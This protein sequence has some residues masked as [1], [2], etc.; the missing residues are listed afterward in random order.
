VTKFNQVSKTVIMSD[1][2]L[3]NTMRPQL[4]IKKQ[5]I[6]A[7]NSFMRLFISNYDNFSETLIAKQDTCQFFGMLFFLHSKPSIR[8]KKVQNI[9]KPLWGILLFFYLQ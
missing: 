9:C 4:Y 7:L 1:H 8:G 3:V 2:V 5:N 6:K